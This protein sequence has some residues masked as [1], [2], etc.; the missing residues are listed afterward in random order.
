MSIYNLMEMDSL[1][2]TC[3]GSIDKVHIC[4]SKGEGMLCTDLYGQER[5]N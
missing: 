5:G 4:L 1:E 2:Q 3:R